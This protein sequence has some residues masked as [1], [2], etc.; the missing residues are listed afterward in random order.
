MKLPK[1]FFIFLSVLLTLP[2]L[3]MEKLTKEGLQLQFDQL[4]E[5]FM[6]NKSSLNVTTESKVEALINST[7]ESLKKKKLK[8]KSSKTVYENITQAQELLD[9]AIKQKK[10]EALLLAR[11]QKM[12]GK[13][14]EAEKQT[15]QRLQ[16]QA[17]QLQQFPQQVQNV[18]YFV[19]QIP[20]PEMLAQPNPITEFSLSAIQEQEPDTILTTL[21]G[22]L[23]PKENIPMLST[24]LHKARPIS[25][26]KVY[27]YLCG[28]GLCT[29]I[30]IYSY[31]KLSPETW[32]RPI[33]LGLSFLGGSACSYLTYKNLRSNK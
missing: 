7:Q 3:S 4:N 2:L 17:P 29:G 21:P 20:E 27:A 12:K 30:G 1:I 10:S 25:W 15:T 31:Y 24:A 28:T 22:L 11:A 26:G 18:E 19:L 13:A 9:S 33:S 8:K 16:C 14:Q 23:H 32:Y 6:E 5:K